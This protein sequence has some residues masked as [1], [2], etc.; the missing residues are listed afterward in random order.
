MVRLTVENTQLVESVRC[1]ALCD[2][3]APVCGETHLLGRTMDVL[4]IRQRGRSK[5]SRQ[6]DGIGATQ[7]GCAA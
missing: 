4:T 5:F 7:S 3:R 6:G 2:F 1:P